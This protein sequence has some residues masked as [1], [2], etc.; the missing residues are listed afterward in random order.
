MAAVVA[1]VEAM[2]VATAVELAAE[3]TAEA[4]VRGAEELVG[5]RGVAVV[6]AE[7]AEE[8]AAGKEGGKAAAA[9]SLRRSSRFRSNPKRFHFWNKNASM[10]SIQNPGNTVR[11]LKSRSLHRI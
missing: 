8:G 2:A 1:T 9:R 11:I 10:G 7:E 6:A 5:A 4:T 3:A